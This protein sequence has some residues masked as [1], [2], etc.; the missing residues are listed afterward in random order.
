MAFAETRTEALNVNAPKDMC[1][2]DHQGSA[3]MRMNV[4]MT[5]HAQMENVLILLEVLYAN[6]QKRVILLIVPEKYAEV[7][8]SDNF[9]NERK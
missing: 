2:V 1:T 4:K 3:W 5:T 6:A 9:V 7:C 8:I